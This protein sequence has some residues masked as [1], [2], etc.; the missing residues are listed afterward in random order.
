MKQKQLSRGSPSP[1]ASENS[2]SKS[3]CTPCKQL[4][5][6]H[7]SELAEAKHLAVGEQCRFR[8]ASRR[9]WVSAQLGDGGKVT[10]KTNLRLMP[11]T[12][13]TPCHH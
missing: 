6:D 8:G 12:A 3:M 11:L 10:W 4:R 2:Q 5:A 13:S 9:L 1:Q 7:C